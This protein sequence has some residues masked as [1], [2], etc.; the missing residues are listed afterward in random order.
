ML[1]WLLSLKAGWEQWDVT[2]ICAA[3]AAA[4][5]VDK[6]DW[7]A[8][9]FPRE[10]SVGAHVAIASINA[11]AMQSLR[12]LAAAG[13][14]FD[15]Q[16]Y[17][18]A[19]SSHGQF[20]VLQYLIDVVHCPWNPVEV[21]KAAAGKGTLEML[22]WLAER[23]NTVWSTATLSHLLDLA[24]QHGNLAVAQWLR[25]QGAEWPSSFLR[26]EWN[27]SH[28]YAT[29]SYWSL[30]TLQWARANGCPCGDWSGETCVRLCSLERQKSTRSTSKGT[31]QLYDAVVWAHAAGCPCD[32]ALHRRAT[33]QLTVCREHTRAQRLFWL[34]FCI[35]WS[36]VVKT[37][38]VLS[39]LTVV[40]CK[41][42]LLASASVPADDSGRQVVCFIFFGQIMMGC[43][44]LLA[45]V[46]HEEVLM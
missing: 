6:L 20:A 31:Q 41:L 39:A 29:C 16:Y 14:T 18:E 10:R 13:Y 37:V 5:S 25:A 33:E 23:E 1:Q 43:L 30:N 38:G 22:L 32:S 19:A 34:G 46:I 40:F 28:T 24:G 3:A 17:T 27:Q 7:L 21:R 36:E 42:Y 4:N 44:F 2:S 35:H 8:T 11:G 26:H 9:R 12:W 15:S 45:F